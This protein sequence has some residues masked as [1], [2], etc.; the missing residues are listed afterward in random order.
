MLGPRG[1]GGPGE[2]RL[3]VVALGSGPLPARRNVRRPSASVTQGRTR[4]RHHLCHRQMSTVRETTLIIIRNA[5]NI[6][7]GSFS[8]FGQSCALPSPTASCNPAEPAAW[9]LSASETGIGTEISGAAK[10]SAC[11]STKTYGSK[12]KPYGH[13][14]V[15]RVRSSLVFGRG[16]AVMGM[17]ES[18]HRASA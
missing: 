4:R 14:H 11:A 1:N 13:D 18:P 16:H 8:S 12:I 10:L 2:L 6:G 15:Q 5:C 17:T 7:C 3:A 9:P